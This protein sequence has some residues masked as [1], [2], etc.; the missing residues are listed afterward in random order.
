METGNP[1]S[2]YAGKRQPDFN[3]ASLKTEE[4]R[5][6]ETVVERIAS[7]MSNVN[8]LLGKTVSNEKGNIVDAAKMF[9]HRA[10][11]VMYGDVPQQPGSGELGVQPIT[12]Q[13]FDVNDFSMDVTAGSR[14]FLWGGPTEDDYFT[15]DDPSGAGAGYLMYVVKNGII[16]KGDKPVTRQFEFNS[17]EVSGVP[18]VTDV[19]V[20][21]SIDE[22]TSLYQYTT[23]GS[24]LVRWDIGTNLSIMPNR[25]ADNVEY[26]ILGFV[27]YERSY[28]S[29]L[30]W[31]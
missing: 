31:L 26:D 7:R 6:I 22:D 16:Q 17:D 28:F 10:G 20:T 4:K 9:K 8:S 27:F 29:T 3:V 21:E 13:D 11:D 2:V 30:R 24:Y 18:F 23:P 19:L 5:G 25:D 15:T 12:P 1:I 14:E